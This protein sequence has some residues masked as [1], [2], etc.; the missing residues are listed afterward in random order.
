MNVATDELEY[1]AQIQKVMRASGRFRELAA[2]RL[3]EAAQT[4]FEKIFL[5]KGKLIGRA[6]FLVES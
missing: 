5:A 6:K 2:D 4:E 1:F 3:P